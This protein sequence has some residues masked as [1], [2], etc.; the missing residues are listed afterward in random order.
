MQ[1]TR[2]WRHVRMNPIAVSRCFPAATLDAIQREIAAQEAMHR[3]EI[4]FVLEPELTT[5]Q[6][7]QGVTPRER[8]RQVFAQQG[9]WNTEENNG[10]LLYVLLAD[11]AVEIVADRGIDAH[12][13]DA[14][15]RAICADMEARFAEGR[16][17]EG[18]IGGVRAI[19][20]AM[21]RHF[22]GEGPRRNEL[23]DRPMVL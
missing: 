3:G 19:A 13:D 6:L 1:L 21:G 8:A 12:L 23:A 22:P 16:F 17:E 2:F 20:Q 14:Q 5:S 15:W 9:I 18:A 4:C 11:R 7:W 10:V